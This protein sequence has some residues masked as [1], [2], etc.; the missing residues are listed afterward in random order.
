MWIKLDFTPLF[1]GGLLVGLLLI[2]I[3]LAIRWNAPKAAALG[4]FIA[5]VGA[6][7]ASLGGFL[8]L[9]DS[10][11]K[12]RD[13]QRNQRWTEQLPEEREIQG[14]RLPRGTKVEWLGRPAT[15]SAATLTL[16]L[17]VLGVPFEGE[18]K[19][20]ST[21]GANNLHLATELDKGTLAADHLIDGVVC[22]AHKEV[23]FFRGGPYTEDTR[24]ARI[25]KL[26]RCTLASELEFHGNRYQSGSEITFNGSD[27][28]DRGILAADQDVDGHWSKAGTEVERPDYRAIRFTLARDETIGRVACKAG[29]EVVLERTNGGVLSAVLSKDQLLDGMPCRGGEAVGF[30]YV[31][32]SYPLD[33]CVLS[34]P[35]TILNVTWPAESSLNAL[36]RGFLEATLPA[37]SSNLTIGEVKIVGRCKIQMNKNPPSLDHVTPDEKGYAELRGARFDG[38]NFYE[39]TSYGH[40]RQPATIAGSRLRSRRPGAIHNRSTEIKLLS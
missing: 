22:K 34:R 32:G 5:I 17:E 40:L 19:F 39:G 30:S 14:V 12:L 28:I 11:G 8:L 9:S 6:I 23:E 13:K 15:I 38:L 31:D 27:G 29:A 36:S 26:R 35:A 25:G 24:Q 16:P 21:F 7:P 33:S 3:G 4:I 37:D 1:V 10:L 20:V 18:L 2:G